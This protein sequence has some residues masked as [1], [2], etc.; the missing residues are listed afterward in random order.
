MMLF[1]NRC[2][3]GGNKHNFQPRYSEQPTRLSYERGAF[4]TPASI[5]KL[6]FYNNYVCDVCTWCGKRTLP[7]AKDGRAK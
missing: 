1:K 7:E 5:R 3:N 4:D 2:Y 6:M